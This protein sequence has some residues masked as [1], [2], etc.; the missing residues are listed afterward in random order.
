[1]EE[2]LAGQNYAVLEYRVMGFGTPHAEVE[3]LFKVIR[4]SWNTLEDYAARLGEL[5]VGDFQKLHADLDD[6]FKKIP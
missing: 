6:A 2:K 3:Y 5:S 1:M 4:E